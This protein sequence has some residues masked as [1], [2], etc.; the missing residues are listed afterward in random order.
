MRAVMTAAFDWILYAVAAVVVVVLLQVFVTTKEVEL[1][2]EGRRRVQHAAT[3]QLLIAISYVLPL[4]VCQVALLAGTGLLLYI[5]HG[6]KDWYQK[7]FGPILRPHEQDSLPGAFWFLMGTFLSSVCFEITIGRYAVLCLSYAD[8]MA[9]WV[10]SSF[11]SP[12]VYGSATLAGCSACFAT[13][14]LIGWCVLSN[15]AVE[16]AVGALACTVAESLPI[17]NDNILI[18]IITASAVQILRMPR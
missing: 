1:S 7:T 4:V 17:G 8:P 18:P 14:T 10:G 11:K 5:Y 6:Q 15:D 2:K 3:G 12:R 9:A 16:I 13:A